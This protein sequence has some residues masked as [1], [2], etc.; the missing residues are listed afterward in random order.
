MIEVS[1]NGS[2]DDD[3]DDE[4][5]DDNDEDDDEDDDDDD[6]DD[7]ID[8]DLTETKYNDLTHEIISENLHFDIEDVNK[9]EEINT[10]E[11]KVFNLSNIT[12]EMASE[13]KSVF[14]QDFKKI[15]LPELK[16][17]AKEQHPSLDISKLKKEELIQLLN[18]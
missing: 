4:E 8:I 12:P 2:N 6:D 13:I 14:K 11:I 17:M 15:K 10:N 3:E 5:D 1:D 18:S 7:D 9:I 16:Q